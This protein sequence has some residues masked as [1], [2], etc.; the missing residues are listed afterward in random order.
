MIF[1]A[2]RIDAIMKFALIKNVVIKRVHCISAISG[3]CSDDN[4]KLCAM[5]DVRRV[6][7]YLVL[8]KVDLNM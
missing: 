3:G 8:S 5:E 7:R 2:G 1:C 4:E 6:I